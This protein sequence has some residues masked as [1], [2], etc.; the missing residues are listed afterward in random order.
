MPSENNGYTKMNYKQFGIKKQL[1]KCTTQTKKVKA[2]I[3][4]GEA[5]VILDDSKKWNKPLVVTKE[6]WEL[7]NYVWDGNTKMWQQKKDKN[8][9]RPKKF[10][11][12]YLDITGDIKGYNDAK[13]TW[14]NF[15]K[16][17]LSST[18]ISRGASS[19]FFAVLKPIDL[20]A[21]ITH[22]SISSANSSR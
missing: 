8:E 21:S 20:M 22:W 10:Q 6:L 3:T 15:A 9:K 2:A 4:A 5:T 1:P 17:F 12:E 11:K 13:T 19:T 16:T 7:N 14:I 18:S